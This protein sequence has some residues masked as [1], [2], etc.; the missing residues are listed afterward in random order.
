[1]W[2]GWIEAPHLILEDQAG[3]KSHRNGLCLAL[4]KDDWYGDTLDKK[5]VE[6]LNREAGG[7][8]SEMQSRWPHLDAE[9]FGME[10]ALCSFKKIFRVRD[11]AIWGTTWIVKRKRSVLLN[12]TAGPES[13]GDLGGR[14][15]RVLR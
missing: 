3:S 2:R 4:G 9:Y 1:M 8:L 7:I 6:W 10:S 12:A 14:A 15:P 13:T 5:Q 11:G